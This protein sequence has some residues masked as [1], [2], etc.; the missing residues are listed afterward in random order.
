MFN[1]LFILKTFLFSLALLLVLQI[2]MGN[3]T[4]E[5]KAMYYLQDSA[6]VYP[7]RDVAEGAV[8]VAGDG[9]RALKSGLKGTV[10]DLTSEE[11]QN[12]RK[13]KP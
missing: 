12:K 2:K 8:R 11:D 9:Y 10:K 6:V 5:E 13:P 4:L 3:D 7:L 1:F